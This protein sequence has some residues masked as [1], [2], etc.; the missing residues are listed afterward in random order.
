[1]N[2]YGNAD[3]TMR[4]VR[5]YEEKTAQV[6]RRSIVKDVEKF[7]EEMG[8]DLKLQHPDLTGHTGEGERIETPKIG[9]WMKKKVQSNGYKEMKSE[10]WQG[11]VITGQWQDDKLAGE[12]FTWRSGKQR[13]RTQCPKP[14]T[15]P[16]A[17]PHKVIICRFSQ[18]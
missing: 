8:I 6:G 3:P 13:Q 15:I 10:K 9:D 5:E 18:G 7:A 16:T 1:M 4:L 11:K 14:G 2:I 17:S 12:C